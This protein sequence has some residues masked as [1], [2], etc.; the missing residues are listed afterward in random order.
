MCIFFTFYCKYFVDFFLTFL[1]R[2]KLEQG[3]CL[4]GSCWIPDLGDCH[5]WLKGLVQNAYSLFGQSIR[6]GRIDDHVLCW[7]AV[8]KVAPLLFLVA[9]NQIRI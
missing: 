5:N 1:V 9:K 2:L 4:V 3:H 7:N 8:C 6:E